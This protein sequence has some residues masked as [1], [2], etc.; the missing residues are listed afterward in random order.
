MGMLTLVEGQRVSVVVNA[1]KAIGN[2]CE[3]DLGVM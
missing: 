1:F 3:F 2:Y